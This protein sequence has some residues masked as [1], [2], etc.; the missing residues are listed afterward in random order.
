MFCVY[1]RHWI[2]D[3]SIM[4][5][6]PRTNK[7]KQPW[8]GTP[9]RIH[10]KKKINWLK[11]FEYISQFACA[12]SAICARAKE[13]GKICNHTSYD[14]KFGNMYMQL[15]IVSYNVWYNEFSNPYLHLIF[16]LHM[17]KFTHFHLYVALMLNT[18]CLF[19][20]PFLAHCTE[21]II[22][23]PLRSTANTHTRIHVDN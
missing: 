6:D 23:S 18:L 5:Y 3:H 9:M 2:W 22:V 12:G 1:D 7:K 14:Q 10:M 16:K 20:F 19:F 8:N 11:P 15:N 13:S 4:F 21:W 17:M